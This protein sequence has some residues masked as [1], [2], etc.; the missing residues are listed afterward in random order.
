MLDKKD[1]DDEFYT[2]FN[3][4]EGIDG[5]PAK[6]KIEWYKNG[7]LR[8][9]LDVVCCHVNEGVAWF[10]VGPLIANGR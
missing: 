8:F 6:G 4:H 9:E 10:A 3:A 7:E 2:E 1:F 5:K